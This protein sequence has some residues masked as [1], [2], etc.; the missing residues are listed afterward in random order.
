VYD[1]FRA[2]ALGYL[3]KTSTPQDVVDAIRL[4]VKG[5][6]KITRKSRPRSSKTSDESRKTT[7]RTTA[8]S[9]C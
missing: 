9:T 8:S 7:A 5:E 3:L 2:G 1:A 4:A 6:A